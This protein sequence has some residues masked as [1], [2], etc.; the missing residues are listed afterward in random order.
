MIYYSRLTVPISMQLEMADISV[1]VTLLS[2]DRSILDLIL[3]MKLWTMFEKQNNYRFFF[4]KFS[5]FHLSSHFLYFFKSH[6]FKS[7]YYNP[8]VIRKIFSDHISYWNSEWGE[9]KNQEFLSLL[10]TSY[11]W[12]LKIIISVQPRKYIKRSCVFNLRILQI[13]SD[14]TTYFAGRPNKPFAGRRV[15]T[16]WYGWLWSQEQLIY[17]ILLYKHFNCPV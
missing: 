13:T 8:N 4:R 11:L 9:E 2:L 10:P 1:P 6:R 16:A 14:A 5:E 17:K 7:D 3:V 15:P 12:E